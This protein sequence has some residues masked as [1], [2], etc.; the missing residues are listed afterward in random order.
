MQTNLSKKYKD[1]EPM[2]TVQIIKDFFESE[3]YQTKVFLN[4]KT[5]INSYWCRI[6]L[7]DKNNQ[8]ILGQNGK[9]TTLEYSLA[10]GYAELYER[11]CAYFHI[12]DFLKFYDLLNNNK[13]INNYFY[14]ENEKYLSFQEVLESSFRIKEAVSIKNSYFYNY[15]L[16]TIA[17]MHNQTKKI[18]CSYFSNLDNQKEGK[19]FNELMVLEITGSDG[20][21]A[22]NTLEEAIVQG[23]SEVYEHF[24]TEQIFKKNIDIFYEIDINNLPLPFYL[25]N[26]LNN[27]EQNNDI[28]FHIFDLSYNFNLPVILGTFHSKSSNLWSINLGSSPIFEIALE[29]VLTEIYQGVKTNLTEKIQDFQNIMTPLKNVKNIN[30]ALNERYAT[31]GHCYCLPENILL[32][33]Q[34]IQMINKEVF[35]TS[36][37]Y[38]N[39]ELIEH[40]KYLNRINNLEVYYKDISKSDNMKAVRIFIA[41]KSIFSFYNQ[42]Q[43]FKQNYKI[44]KFFINYY[45]TSYLNFK[46]YKQLKKKKQVNCFFQDPFSLI[47]INS[48]KEFFNSLKNLLYQD[49]SFKYYIYLYEYMSKN[50]YLKEEIKNIFKNILLLNIDTIEQ[51]LN[52]INDIEYLFK[53][54]FLNKYVIN[55][56]KGE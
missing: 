9:G 19:Y 35:L 41:N 50:K 23:L 52:N 22:G 1:R 15:Y 25:L 32:Q 8:E 47:K 43:N 34:K 21:A 11:Y 4:V 27:L 46:K 14:E 51:D 16:K 5:D 54:L 49:Q 29:R 37:N 56:K 10:S 31:I 18:P 30:T 6:I 38:T 42:K 13:K 55:F 36:Q 48:K 40:Y 3:G 24:V 7:L 28:E 39:Y 17:L 2:E 44:V 45:H 53:E 20:T 12:D 26:L 33:T